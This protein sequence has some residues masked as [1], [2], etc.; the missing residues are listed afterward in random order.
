MNKKHLF[1]T[2]LLVLITI[3]TACNEYDPAQQKEIIKSARRI[4]VIWTDENN[5][6]SSEEFTI[7]IVDSCEYLVAKH[8]RS[9][10]I[11]HKGNCK[12]CIA[13]NKK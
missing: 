12:F 11:T 13:R 6:S 9:R 1:T 7:I 8:D 2:L 5:F 10:I 4:D 3:I